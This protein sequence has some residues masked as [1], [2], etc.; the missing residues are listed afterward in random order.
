MVQDLMRA[1]ESHAVTSLSNH[2]LV[3]VGASGVGHD[4]AAV[5]RWLRFA[6]SLRESINTRVPRRAA[7]NS[8]G[9]ANEDVQAGAPD[10]IHTQIMP[11]ANN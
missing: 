5:R 2:D 8:Q 9:D 1:F 7:G 3:A 11:L 6:A 4:R 10:P